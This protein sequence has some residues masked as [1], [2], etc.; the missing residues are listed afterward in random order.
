MLISGNIDKESLRFGIMKV[1]QDQSLSDI[2]TINS[3]RQRDEFTSYN[4]TDGLQGLVGLHTE[5]KTTTPIQLK[6]L[7]VK[8]QYLERMANW[9]S[10]VPSEKQLAR[11]NVNLR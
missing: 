4:D 8:T 11:L 5:L 7:K 10:Y 3:L 1:T 9:D 6:V 2:S